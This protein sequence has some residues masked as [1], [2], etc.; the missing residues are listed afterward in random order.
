M[1]NLDSRTWTHAHTAPPPAA[2]DRVPTRTPTSYEQS[3]VLQ[4][5]PYGGMQ[6]GT[7]RGAKVFAPLTY[8]SHHASTQDPSPLS[9][10]A[11]IAHSHRCRH[12]EST[13]RLN[14][15]DKIFRTGHR[16]VRARAPRVHQDADSPAGCGASERLSHKK[17]H[18]LLTGHRAVN[19]VRLAQ[20]LVE[21]EAAKFNVMHS[22]YKRVLYMCGVRHFTCPTSKQPLTMPS[23][24]TLTH[25]MK[26]LSAMLPYAPAV[27]L[28]TEEAPTGPA[29]EVL[30]RKAACTLRVA[31]CRMMYLTY[32]YRS[33]S[34]QD[35]FRSQAAPA[36]TVPCAA[37]S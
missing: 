37:L 1:C 16:A 34:N 3:C 29:H 33:M 9:K 18:T 32:T 20:A 6:R 4:C 25:C 5:G 7:S 19:T 8:T 14:T 30:V 24:I 17:R 10:C 21:Q 27:A 22:S 13:S 35:C 15:F 26:T 23:R 11:Y 2:Y 31:P 28:S 12:S 36:A